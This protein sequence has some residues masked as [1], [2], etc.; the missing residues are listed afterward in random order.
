MQSGSAPPTHQDLLML[1]TSLHSVISLIFNYSVNV[2][3]SVSCLSPF[4]II[5]IL[6]PI[7]HFLSF[8]DIHCSNSAVFVLTSCRL[9]AST[10]NM[11]GNIKKTS[12]KWIWYHWFLL[13]MINTRARPGS[14]SVAGGE[15]PHEGEEQGQALR[16]QEASVGAQ[17]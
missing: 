14:V 10:T 6:H 9:P 16:S 13:T 15:G 3:F 7:A 17:W 5:R 2:S 12:G 4:H 1:L 11:P 8:V